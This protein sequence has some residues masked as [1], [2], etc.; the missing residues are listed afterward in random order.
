MV[1][2][3]TF[4]EMRLLIS[5]PEKASTQSSVTCAMTRWVHLLPMSRHHF[6]YARPLHQLQWETVMLFP[7]RNYKLFQ[8]RYEQSS[9]NGGRVYCDPAELLS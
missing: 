5:L 8:R 7:M 4:H 3:E 2:Q 1:M 9:S 6:L